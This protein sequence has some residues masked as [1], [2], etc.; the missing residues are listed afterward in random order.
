M[1]LTLALI[2]DAIF[3]EP[4]WLWS[5]LRHPVAL[6]GTLIGWT[7][8]QFN[9]GP[10]RR[11]KGALIFALLVAASLLAGAALAAVPG[12]WIDVIVAAIL[13]SYRSL[14]SHISAVA[15]A[16]AI[17]TALARAEVAKIVGR[18]TGAMEPAD[19]ARATIESAAENF[20]DGVVAPAFWFVVFGLPGLLAYKFTNTADSMIGY[21]TD[22]YRDFGWAAARTDDLLNWVPA[23][24]TATIIALVAR[25]ANKLGEIRASAGHH[26]SPNAGWPEAAM[27]SALDVALAGP[28]TYDGQT[29]DY[30]FVHQ[31][32]RKDIAG[33]EVRAAVQLLWRCW[34]VLLAAA[35]LGW[36]V[37]G[38]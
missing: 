25:N 10:N 9:K 33:A 36:I 15:S 7:D 32:G 20:S 6:M 27:A 16:L 23:R 19:I 17:G 34:L 29:I 26:R 11:A 4:G 24:L 5:R 21:K 18:D 1:I 22:Q 12:R 28:R 31:D 14:V 38:M 2:L 3:G 37:W 13:L 8:A 30:P 35:V